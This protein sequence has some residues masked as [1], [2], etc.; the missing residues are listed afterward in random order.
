MPTKT[1]MHAH[2]PSVFRCTNS[3]TTTLL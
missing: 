3:T 2:P 1:M